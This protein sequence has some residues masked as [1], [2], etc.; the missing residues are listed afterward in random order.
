MAKEPYRSK[1]VDVAV[2][3]REKIRWALG[4][5]EKKTKALTREIVEQIVATTRSIGAVP[6]LVYMPVYD[7]VNDLSDSMSA[8]EQY[9]DDICTQQGIAC[10]FLRPRFREDGAKRRMKLE[11][12]AHWNPEMHRS[13][14]EE[15]ARFLAANRLV[16]RA[17]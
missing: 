1:A 6:V 16:E 7:E 14:A 8:R 15:I 13:A 17:H 10:L 12:R 11:T 5:N 4:L 2:I 9:V 3:L